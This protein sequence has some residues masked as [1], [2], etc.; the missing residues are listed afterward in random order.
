MNDKTYVLLELKPFQI[1]ARNAFCQREHLPSFP[2]RLICLI[3]V[4]HSMAECYGDRD[5]PGDSISGSSSNLSGGPAATAAS[6]AGFSKLDRIKIF[7]KLLAEVIGEENQV[8]VVVFGTNA[9]VLLPMCKMTA[10]AKQKMI[11][12]FNGIALRGVTN[13]SAGLFTAI[14]QF[15]KTFAKKTKYTN[16]NILLFSDGMPN[17]G[18]L[19][20]EDLKREIRKRIRRVQQECHYDP[21]YT[22]KIST[23]GTSGFFPESLYNLSRSFSSSPFHHLGEESDLSSDLMLPILYMMETAIA[24]VKV[25]ITALNG[26]QFETLNTEDVIKTPVSKTDSSNSPGSTFETVFSSTAWDEY[27]LVKRLKSKTP[28][29]HKLESTRS[30]PLSPDSTDKSASPLFDPFPFF[31]PHLHREYLVHDLAVDMERHILLPLLLPKK[32]KKL[33]KGKDVLSISITYRDSTT[34]NAK[35][36]KVINFQDIPIKNEN[37]DECS[38]LAVANCICRIMTCEALDRAAGL[39]EKLDRNSGVITLDTTMDT[40]KRDCESLFKADSSNEDETLANV[41][42]MLDPYLANL[43]RCK[44]YTA[45]F[46][47][48]WDDVW[49]RLKSLRSS[50][51]LEI[52]TSPVVYV[53]KSQLFLTENIEKKKK[54]IKRLLPKIKNEVLDSRRSSVADV[55]ASVAVTYSPVRMV[56]VSDTEQIYL[57][58]KIVRRESC[59][60]PLQT[61]QR[62]IESQLP[63]RLSKHRYS[64]Q[65]PPTK[66]RHQQQQQQQQQQFL[67]QQQQ[68]HRHMIQSSQQ[69]DVESTNSTLNQ[70]QLSGKYTHQIIQQQPQQPQQLQPLQLQ[71]PQKLQQVRQQQNQQPSQQYQQK[72]PRSSQQLQQQYLQQQQTQQQQQIRPPNNQQHYHKEQK[73]NPNTPNS[74]CSIKNQTDDKY[75]KSTTSNDAG[76]E[77]DD[78][79]DDDDDGDD[80]D[81]DDD[82]VATTDNN[83]DVTRL[84][85]QV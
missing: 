33:L 39:L 40:L 65:P 29:K 48:R 72:L 63:P 37:N 77:G 38:L 25:T 75:R 32:H 80:D 21:D 12:A 56:S 83:D 67:F 53:D 46:S 70:R 6:A 19:D 68:Q 62:T 64:L 4:S 10:D 22:I 66:Q 17:E 5:V 24:N 69:S 8:G 3:D 76:D 23:A 27:R 50:L 35:L 61:I 52:L 11:A 85:T 43:N 28:P 45:D 7:G 15:S 47:V 79:D 42:K 31:S 2:L 60:K 1:P 71:Q 13:I 9:E 16:D 49:S 30:N 20:R 84:V 41:Y 74:K 82:A 55:D 36:Q 58:K 14:E 54:L 59:K 18:I 81:E 57:K 73:Q 26:V 78:D 34:N 44:C 51:S